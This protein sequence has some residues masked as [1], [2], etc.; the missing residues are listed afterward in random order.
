[1]ES[2]F[3]WVIREGLS[4]KVIF[5][6]SRDWKW[7]VGLGNTWVESVPGRGNRPTEQRGGHIA[8]ME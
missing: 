1:M 4:G 3:G 7:G 8:G 2:N 5:E 6:Q